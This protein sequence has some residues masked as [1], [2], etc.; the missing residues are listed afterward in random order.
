VKENAMTELTD[1]FL[2]GVNV[3][4]TLLKIDIRSIEGGQSRSIDLLRSV[5]QGDEVLAYLD[6]FPDDPEGRRKQA[7]TEKAIATKLMQ[8]FDSRS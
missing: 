8:D 3:T 5:S 7:E 1:A 6:D 2:M 4:G